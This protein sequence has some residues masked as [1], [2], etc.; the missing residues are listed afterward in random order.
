MAFVQ[1]IEFRTSKMEEMR[2]LAE[3]LDQAIAGRHKV[4]R[5]IWCRDR[6]DPARYFNIVFFDSYEE[7]MKNSALPE[8]DQFATI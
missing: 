1:M 7:A 5:D 8:I 3:E 4:R 6:E 2:R